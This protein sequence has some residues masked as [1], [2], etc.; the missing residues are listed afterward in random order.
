MK[1]GL[2]FILALAMMLG[3]LAG[4]RRQHITARRPAAVLRRAA[5]DSDKPFAGRR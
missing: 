2:A 1:R 3:M 5:G 4:L